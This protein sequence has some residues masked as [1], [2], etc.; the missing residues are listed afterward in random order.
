MRH[1]GRRSCRAGGAFLAGETAGR[2][3]GAIHGENRRG[4][5]RYWSWR[6]V[7]PA[8][9]LPLVGRLT[10]DSGCDQASERDTVVASRWHQSLSGVGSLWNHGGRTPLS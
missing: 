1:H 8:P 4:A 3:L 10:D 9:S 5:R 2:K 7:R 6:T